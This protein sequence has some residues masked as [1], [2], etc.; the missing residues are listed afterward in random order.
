MLSS[1][2]DSLRDC[3]SGSGGGKRTYLHEGPEVTKLACELVL[4]YFLFPSSVSGGRKR[5]LI[6]SIASWKGV[7]IP[8][9]DPGALSQLDVGIG[10]PGVAY[11][12]RRPFE[13]AFLA[14]V[15]LALN[16][17]Q[18]P[19]RE[20]VLSDHLKFRELL[21]DVE[22]ASPRQRQG[23]DILLLALSRLLRADCQPE[24][25]G[26][27]CRGICRGSRCWRQYRGS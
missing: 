22:E 15:A 11:N 17:Q 8:T 20:A 9:S 10:G 24:P 3:H 21:D 4:V 2:L 5:Q 25:Q 1:L 23:R 16:A 26:A 7:S 13:I 27:N 19:E 6:E 18:M 14:E 12:T